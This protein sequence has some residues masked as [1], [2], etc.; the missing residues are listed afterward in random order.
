MALRLQRDEQ[1]TI[2]LTPLI[3]IVFLLIIFFMVGTKFSELDEAEKNLALQVPQVTDTKALTEAPRKRNVNVMK[4]GTILL[5]REPVSLDQLYQRLAAAREQY[6]Q[7]GVVVRG[8]SE[9]I[10]QHVADVIA[11]CRRAE[12]TDLSISVRVANKG[13]TLR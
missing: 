12:I 8:D 4:D 1:A 2:N 13:A 5:D 3:D 10:Y 7:T 11:T 6:Q 9:S